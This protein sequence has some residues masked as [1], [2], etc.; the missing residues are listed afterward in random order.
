MPETGFS[1]TGDNEHNGDDVEKSSKQSSSSYSSDTEDVKKAAENRI[2]RHHLSLTQGCG[3]STCQN[4]NC[5]SSGKMTPL[6]GN[7]AAVKALELFSSHA[8]EC[9]SF[10]SSASPEAISSSSSRNRVV[11]FAVPGDAGNE[12]ASSSPSGSRLSPKTSIDASSRTS[13]SHDELALME[14]AKE[15]KNKFGIKK[16]KKTEKSEGQEGGLSYELLVYTMDQCKLLGGYAKL[17]MLLWAVFSNELSLKNSFPKIKC[18]SVSSTLEKTP[19]SLPSVA[20]D[21][22]EPQAMAVDADVQSCSGKDAEEMTSLCASPIEMS[23]KEKSQSSHI[24][25]DKDI[26]STTDNDSMSCD[27]NTSK[28]FQIESQTSRGDADNSDESMQIDTCVIADSSSDDLSKSNSSF[29]MDVK[30][31]CSKEDEGPAKPGS[32]K[33]TKVLGLPASENTIGKNSAVGYTVL[34][35]S[36][37]EPS[38]N[39]DELQKSYALLKTVPEESLLEPLSEFF[40]LL[41]EKQQAMLVVHLAKTWSAQRLESFVSAF[42][43]LITIKL[44]T[45]ESGIGS[46]YESQSIQYEKTICNATKS[47][48]LVFM[49]SVVAGEVDMPLLRDTPPSTSFCSSSLFSGSEGVKTPFLPPYPHFD[50]LCSVLGIHPLDS[51]KPV[52]KFSEFYDEFL[53]EQLEVDKDYAFYKSGIDK[54]S[55]LH[56]PYILT[57]ATKALALY[58]D[59]RIRMYSERRMSVIQTITVGQ[60][61]TPY[62]RLRVRRDQII[63]DALVE[64]EVVAMQSPLELRKQLVVEFEGEQGIDEGGVSK[65]FFQLITE[66]LFCPDFGMFSVQPETQLVWFNPRSFESEA[67]FSLVG[68]VLGL[69][70][71]NNVILDLHLPPVLYKKLCGKPGTFHDLKDHNPTVYRSILSLLEYE[72]DDMEDVFVQN[73]C[74]GCQDVFGDVLWHD[75]KEDGANIMVGQHNK[76]EFVALYSD[77]LLNGMVEEQFRPFLRGFL[78]VT[79]ESPLNKLFRP[80]ELELLLCGSQ[81]YDFSELE[82]SAEYDGGYSSTT[83]VVAWFWELVNAMTADEQMQLLQFATGSA[84]A[85]VGGL[86]HLKLVIA[87]HGPDTDRLPTAHTCFNVL[88]LPEYSSKEKLKDRL[89]KA[90]KYS[91]GF[92]ML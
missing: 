24:D 69:A 14:V 82:K 27:D 4:R 76:H 74:V 13:P 35:E 50:P 15:S 7:E 78:M 77:W 89:M 2:R 43:H 59:N 30:P 31:S 92:G 58:Y 88:L 91:Q 28:H 81:Q 45:T 70:I 21:A 3:S 61:A 18:N 39:F 22:S 86:A 42:H 47:M 25:L 75:L 79:D 8:P 41:G 63:N 62:L 52:V 51:R 44:I 36:I 55:F 1:E 87:R 71:Y 64:L 37:T 57:P 17:R 26:D 84:R 68:L 72:G 5:V 10:S 49:A 40:T 33:G 19:T 6:S 16:G 46:E 67:Q 38:I 32:E 56:H 29:L 85:P 66:Q 12:D 65:E 20:Q 80:D 73:F 90:I 54:F 83:P 9:T 60:P 11:S 53:S 34:K 48:F 23:S